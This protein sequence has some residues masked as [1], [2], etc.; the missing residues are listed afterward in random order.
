[1]K[2]SSYFTYSGPGRIGISMTVPDHLADGLIMF[3]ALAPKIWFKGADINVYHHHYFQMLSELDPMATWK[4][5][6]DLAGDH[7]PVLLCWE[8]PPF[9]ECN[10]CHR[11]LVAQWFENELGAIVPEWR[12][13]EI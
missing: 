9:D 6:H 4:K 8:K 11:R 2:T 13:E 5:L 10:F 7:E 1:M 3:R 12:P